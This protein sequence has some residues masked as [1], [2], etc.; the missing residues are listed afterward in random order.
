[1]VAA[2][3]RERSLSGNIRVGTSGWSYPSGKGTWNGIFY[4]APRPRG[5]D[6]LAFYA[7]HFDT[8]EVNSTFYRSPEAAQTAKWV[9]RT[10][11]DFLFSVK[12]FQKFTHPDMYLA[13]GGSTNWEPSRVD[14]DLF[15]AGIEPLAKAHKLGALV[16]QFPPSFHDGPEARAYLDWLLTA[17]SN[18][19]KA[20]E[21]RHKS[22]SDQSADV[23]ALLAAHAAAWVL[24]DEPKFASSVRQTVIAPDERPDV[25]RAPLAYLRLHGRNAERWWEHD[26][27]ED[28][29]NYL[30][31]GDELAPFAERAEQ[32]ARAGKKV[33]LYL[34]NHFSAK[35]VAN[36]AVLQRRLDQPV[37]GEY[38]L[39]FRMAYGAPDETDSPA[40]DDVER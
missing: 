19:A 22:W 21:L 24:I 23:G 28:R 31:S 27:A 17:L 26:A 7:E 33:F 3:R 39:A 1:M 29:Y 10:P 38:G 9:E 5:F 32:D 16:M 13:R 2:Q 25:M 4:P 40:D 11:E 36:A 34:N 30:Y 12:L 8:V 6:E 20:V 35:A 15:R 14:V 37:R 18:Y